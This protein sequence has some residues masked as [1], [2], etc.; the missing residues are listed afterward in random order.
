MRRF[1]TPLLIIGCLMSLLLSCFSSALF[2]DQQFSYRDAAHYYYPLYQ[3]VQ[4]EWD[5]GRWPLW[6][7]EE[8][9]GM[10]LLGNPTAAV[11]YPGKILYAM[12][13]YA[14]GARLYVVAHTVLA[15]V[16]MLALMRGWGT[17]WT[18]STVSALTYAFAAPILFQYCNI[19]FLV[20]AAWTPLGFRAADRWLR[21]GE[22]MGLLELAVV[23]SL[24]TLGGDPQSTYITGVCAVGYAFALAW[25]RGR[26]TPWKIRTGLV[27][28]IA[29]VSALGYVAIV[30]GLAAILPSYRVRHMPPL[31]L[32]WMPWAPPVVLA[33]WGLIGAVL[34]VRWARGKRESPLVPMLTGLGSAGILA[35]LLAAA[36]LL[37]VLEFTRRSGRAAGGG[38][39]DIYPFSLEPLRL[40]ELAWPNIFGS[41]FAGNNHWLALVPYLSQHAHIWVP[42][43]YMGGLTLILAIG[44]F[45]FRNASPWR[46]WLSAI[47]LISLVASMGEYSSPIWWARQIPA[48]TE[49]LGP[50]DPQDVAALRQDGK[51]RDGDGGVYWLLSTLLPGF[52]QFRYPS[53]LLSFTALSV[54]GLAGL[55]LDDVLVRRRRK[56]E[57]TAAMFF[58][59]SLVALAIALV[60][61]QQIVHAF[62]VGAAEQKSIF[63]PFNPQGA[64]DEMFWS[65]VAGTVTFALSLL[66]VLRGQRVPR[67]AAAFALILVTADLAL[68][69]SRYIFTVPQSLMDV[70]PKLVEL[71]EKA[72]RESPQPSPTPFRVHR[73]PIWD[74]YVWRD[75]ASSDRVADF[76]TWERKT[77]QPKY[78]VPYGIQ[79]TLTMGVAELYDY[80]WFFGGFLQTPDTEMAR[81]L[82]ATPGEKIVVFPRRAF[83]LW[84][85]RYFV[86]PSLPNG[87]K[88]EHRGFAAF[89]DDSEL[90]YPP[91][92]L[93]KGPGGEQRQKDWVMKEDYQLYRNRKCYPRAWVVHEGK[94]IKPI[95]GMGRTDRE[96]P[97]IEI[98]FENDHFW[99]DPS[100]RVYN[101]REMAW[102][103]S[104]K[105]DELRPYL[106][107]GA[108]SAGETVTITKYGEQRV[109]LDVALDR[110]GLVVL[111]DVFYPGWRLTIDGKPAPIYRANR[112]MRGAAVSSGRHHLVYSYEPDSFRM[113]SRLSLAGLAIVATL[114]LVFRR[115]PYSP[116]LGA[117]SALAG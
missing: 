65:L 48:V 113:G 57:V 80:D 40:F 20:G 10:P 6:E 30:L 45:G 24:Q 3:K 25:L 95:V 56:T 62:L 5:A 73:M 84:N 85:T 91:P 94:P 64:Y 112:L 108:S 97:M 67:E 47:A 38:P 23:L 7:T 35:G 17:S 8:N 96:G 116:R 77:I 90:V 43:L 11:L 14:W 110:P 79:Y 18:G 109:E 93:F 82:G 27:A 28:A 60:R 1:F 39:H 33:V 46:G 63:G 99:Y 104:D 37:P 117:S 29:V 66:L 74:P 72:E 92:E 86:I 75:Q 61:R 34:I 32:A 69:N 9:G 78:G 68:A 12:F 100:L 83:D 58:G 107:Q 31:P 88:D 53:K 21:R 105:S 59:L 15:F 41:N 42:S 102:V 22:R 13:P 44:V 50:L 52:N 98:L 55:G 71:I 101:P 54:A 87:W 103:D 89:I 2:R 114:S 49:T 106:S 26:A 111:A 16:A 115:R 19:I 51:L 76:V 36:Q 70:T 4:K 81:R